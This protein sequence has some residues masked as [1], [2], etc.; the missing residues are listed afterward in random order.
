MIVEEL[1]SNIRPL[2]RIYAFSSGEEVCTWP[3]YF[4]PNPQ[5]LRLLESKLDGVSGGR[6]ERESR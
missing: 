6:T 2:A 3:V 5:R 1:A 4:C